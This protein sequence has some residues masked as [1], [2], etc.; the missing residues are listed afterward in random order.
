MPKLTW[1]SCPGWSLDAPQILVLANNLTIPR[2]L[3]VGNAGVCPGRTPNYFVPQQL[4]R[5]FGWKRR[6]DAGTQPGQEH[7]ADGL[8]C[9][10]RRRGSR[11]ANP[12]SS[13]ASALALHQSTDA[14]G[15]LKVT[16][17]FLS[18]FQTGEY[19][20]PMRNLLTDF[21][22]LSWNV[23]ALNIHLF[24]VGNFFMETLFLVSTK[25]ARNYALRFGA[26]MTQV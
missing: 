8:N 24:E 15:T 11:A 20:E 3:P 25:D 14:T 2:A 23:Y 7:K 18:F 26:Q 19:L 4:V 10:R 5:C 1:A 17:A 9:P 12:A 21:P 6:G 16:F 22:W 13:P